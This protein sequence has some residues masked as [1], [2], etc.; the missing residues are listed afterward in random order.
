MCH[1]HEELGPGVIRAFLDRQR[2]R[3]K[4]WEML[5]DHRQDLPRAYA[6]MDSS[7]SD[8]RSMRTLMM[9]GRQFRTTLVMTMQHS[10]KYFCMQ[11]S[12]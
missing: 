8:D 9:N 1:A 11:E 6:V 4:K 10:L 5:G 12:Y 7:W 3:L 2:R